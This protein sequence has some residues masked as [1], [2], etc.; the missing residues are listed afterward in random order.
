MSDRI[1]NV[2]KFF[3][4]SNIA[5]RHAANN[6]AKAISKDHKKQIVLDFYDIESVSRSFF[7][8]LNDLKKNSLKTKKI[9][10]INLNNDL[11]KLLTIVTAN[12]SKK[13]SYPSMKNVT[14]ATV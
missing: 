6:L 3:R 10:F 5:T 11:E 12:T 13:M 2:A 8:Q 14:Y 4:L 7:D 9:K 1:I